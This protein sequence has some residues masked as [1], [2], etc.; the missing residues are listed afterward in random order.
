ML[1][2]FKGLIKVLLSIKCL[3]YNKTHSVRFMARI[4]IRVKIINMGKAGCGYGTVH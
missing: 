1:L 2:Y 3:N 4:N